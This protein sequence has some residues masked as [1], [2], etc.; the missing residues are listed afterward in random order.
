MKIYIK[1]TLG[2][3]FEP[4]DTCDKPLGKGGQAA[5]YK[6]QTKGSEDFCLKKF[7]DNA[8]AVYDRIVYM[9]KNPP[10][11]IMSN[12]SFRVCWPTALAYDAEKVYRLCHAAGI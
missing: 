9:I 6:I 1:R 8:D 7:N 5:V 10:K 3:A 4:L 11:N 2:S 12:S